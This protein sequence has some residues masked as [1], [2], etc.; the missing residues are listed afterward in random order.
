MD[1]EVFSKVTL[2]AKRRECDFELKRNFSAFEFL[3]MRDLLR[4]WKGRMSITP[5][6][7][8]KHFKLQ[9]LSFE[10]YITAFCNTC[11]CLHQ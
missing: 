6:F 11:H 4:V 9:Y 8:L 2:E 5:F 10:L 7:G 3:F 1:H